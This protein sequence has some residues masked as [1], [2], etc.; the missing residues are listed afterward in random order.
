MQADTVIWRGLERRVVEEIAFAL[1]S[2]IP[3]AALATITIARVGP[4]HGVAFSIYSAAA[5]H[6]ILIDAA[7]VSVHQ[8][9]HGERGRDVLVSGR[10]GQQLRVSCASLLDR[11]QERGAVASREPRRP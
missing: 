6:L 8:R 5:E 3:D 10:Y 9:P 2:P 1:S 7:G 11:L 4:A